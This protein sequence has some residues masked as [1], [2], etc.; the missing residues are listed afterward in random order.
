MFRQM[1]HGTLATTGP[2]QALVTFQQFIVLAD[3]D[4]VVDMTPESISRE[5]TI[6]IEI[7][8]I[9][10]TALEQPDKDSRTPDEEGRRIVRL[11]EGRTWGWRIVNYKHYRELKREEDRKAY[12]RQYW[13]KRK[14]NTSTN[15]QQ[16]QPIS[17]AEAKTDANANEKSEEGRRLARELM[18]SLKRKTAMP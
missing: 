5:T 8:R 10:I 18:E 6:P 14:L 13:H 2:W 4:G 12:H 7:I 9:G 3:R 17:E 11:S 16:T 15:T 1:Y